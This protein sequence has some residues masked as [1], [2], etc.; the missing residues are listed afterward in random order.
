VLR[1]QFCLSL[2]VVANHPVMMQRVSA[3]LV[4]NLYLALSASESNYFMGE[5]NLADA[6]F[7]PNAFPIGVCSLTGATT[8]SLTYG[9]YTCN[10]VDEV[11]FENYGSDGT[12]T[13]TPDSTM[14]YARN[15]SLREGDLNSF[16]CGGED[17]YQV[18]DTCT[19]PAQEGVD[20]AEDGG[21][22]ACCQDAGT[23][24]I[25][26]VGGG[27]LPYTTATGV[28]IPISPGNATVP[29]SYGLTECD[30][31]DSYLGIYFTPDCSGDYVSTAS[32]ASADSCAFFDTLTL[33]IGIEVSAHIYRVLTS[34]MADTVELTNTTYCPLPT[35]APTK[36]PTGTTE[37]PTS[38]PTVEP[39]APSASP[40]LEPTV[41]EDGEGDSAAALCL[42]L[43]AIV[44]T[45]AFLF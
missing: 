14:T 35:M 30:G 20:P 19:V 42:A 6:V 2:E 34:C 39:T 44:S 28:C 13:S 32:A 31:V 29:A 27:C 9:V 43:S 16:N 8:S 37:E 41:E 36:E 25:A 1:K 24:V 22:D 15:D 26:L 18:A 11:L 45:M 5:I 7:Q 10:T 17:N 4:A 33:D 40:T 12:C 38:S 3:A 21:E 23:S